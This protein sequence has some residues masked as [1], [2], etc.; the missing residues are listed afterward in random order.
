MLQMFSVDKCHIHDSNNRD[1]PDFWHFI[2]I[3]EE[4]N[5]MMDAFY[6]HQFVL[7]CFH[8][9]I[10]PFPARRSFNRFLKTTDH[11]HSE[12]TA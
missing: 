3:T 11:D 9:N 5:T 4:L 6:L 12:K 7:I 1:N 10:K 2:I 8:F